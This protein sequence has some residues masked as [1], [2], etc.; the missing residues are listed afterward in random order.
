[1]G[2]STFLKLLIGELEPVRGSLMAYFLYFYLFVP[3]ALKCGRHVGLMIRALAPLIKPL[4]ES[5]F[6]CSRVRHFALTV[7]L[8]T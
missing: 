4:L 2:K 3:Q 7:P 6:F 5:L 1:M 8:F